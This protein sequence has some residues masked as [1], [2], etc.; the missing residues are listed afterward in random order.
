MSGGQPPK[1]VL[2]YGPP[3]TGK[4]MLAR[5]MAGESDVA[6]IQTSA[7]EFLSKYVG[8]GEAKIRDTFKAARKYAPAI[9]FI[10]EIDAIGKKRTGSETTNATENLLT[11]LLTEMDGFSSEANARKPVFVLAATNYGVK[12]DSEEI[13]EL[14]EALM[15][16][17]DNK[18]YVDLPNKDERAEYISSVLTKK[19]VPEIDSGVIENI[20]ERT[21][22]Q[23]LATLQNVVD[24]AFRNAVREEHT[25]GK[26]DLLKGLE[27]Y[28]YGEKRENTPEYYR[29]VAIHETGHAV[30]SYL[31]GEQPSYITIESRGNFGG[32]TQ[33]SSL[34]DVRSYTKDMLIGQIRTMLAGRAAEQIFYG[35]DKSLNTGASSDLEQAT[36]CAL[37]IVCRYGMMDG[38]LMVFKKN[39][40]LNSALA[41]R[42]V[43][44]IN[45]ILNDEMAYTL[46]ELTK[47]KECIEKVANELLA[48][49][50]LTGEEFAKLMEK[51]Q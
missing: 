50:H 23:S 45:A 28:M 42:Y 47:N 18:I 40:I 5:A 30:M 10:D 26:N 37:Q 13:A 16:R 6:F 14:D 43:D 34:E 48:Y 20:A 11:A 19:K 51:Q 8:G 9:I 49:N 17:F 29:E 44:Q 7:S 36:Q 27:E 22:G 2:L 24:L 1:G 21:A 31:Q 4:T 3:G 25:V 46:S 15:R 12:R 33:N 39:E 41:P 35:K 38:Q 32:Y